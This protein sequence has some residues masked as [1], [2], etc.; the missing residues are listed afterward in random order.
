MKKLLSSLRSAL[1]DSKGREVPDPIPVA[2]EVPFATPI[3]EYDRIRG[4]IRTEMSRAAASQ[5][6][7]TFEEAD[8]FDL[9]DEEWATPYEEVFDP[10]PGPEGSL[11]AEG[12]EA[13][14]AEGD[15]S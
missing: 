11:P 8:D 4:L 1:I 7:E 15:P 6:F 2:D 9:E 10:G 3:S 14:P 13:P 5:Q 12:R